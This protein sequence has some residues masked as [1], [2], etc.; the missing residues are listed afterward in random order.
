MKT[1]VV[2]V[3]LFFLFDHLYGSEVSVDNTSEYNYKVSNYEI[4]S[5]ELFPSISLAFAN[6]AIKDA[7]LKFVYARDALQNQV[8]A[9]RVQKIET[10]VYAMFTCKF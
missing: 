7:K 3:A 6:N 4:E 5:G 2:W 8:N 9:N 1:I 10:F